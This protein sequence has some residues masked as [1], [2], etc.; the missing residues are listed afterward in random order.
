MA[1]L[2][3]IITVGEEKGSHSRVEVAGGFEDLASTDE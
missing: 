3:D 2:A 1:S